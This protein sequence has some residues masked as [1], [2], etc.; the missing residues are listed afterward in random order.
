MH[1]VASAWASAQA[2]PVCCCPLWG[3]YGGL[4]DG[5]KRWNRAYVHCAV[6]APG[7]G[8]THLANWWLFEG[9][10][11][12]A[13]VY[14]MQSESDLL[15]QL[16]A[17]TALQLPHADRVARSPILLAGPADRRAPD[18]GAHAVT[19][20]AIAGV[21]GMV[22]VLVTH[23][24]VSR[25]SAATM[26]Q[27]VL[28][29]ARKVAGTVRLGKWGADKANAK[30]QVRIELGAAAHFVKARLWGPPLQLVA[31]VIRN[32][33]PGGRPW[34]DVCREWR[35][36]S[37]AMAEVAWNGST[38]FSPPFLSRHARDQVV[39]RRW[40]PLCLVAALLSTFEPS[41]RRL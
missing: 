27:G 31:P 12:W 22:R 1:K 18:F 2:V 24:G 30:G 37:A 34:V 5:T 7:C 29:G 9:S 6:V 32:H 4:Y 10:E 13:T 15:T 40:I 41:L 17:A 36:A 3:L 28:K 14:S 21:N 19:R 38:M 8:P 23:G 20:V 39:H 11:M 35:E 33:Q 26:V 16:R 25:K